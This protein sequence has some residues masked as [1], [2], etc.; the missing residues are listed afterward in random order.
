[1]SQSWEDSVNVRSAFGLD[2]AGYSSG[3]SPLA[4]GWLRSDHIDVRIA[5][6][7]VFSVQRSGSFQFADPDEELDLFRKMVGEAPV[8]VDVPID[9]QGLPSVQGAHRVWQLTKRAV[10]VALGALPPLAD[11]IGAPVARLRRIL[12]LTQ[13][14]SLLGERIFESY[15]AGSL[16]QMN[17]GCRYKASTADV[18]ESGAWASENA[19]FVGL[20][21][22]LHVHA[23]VGTVLTDDHLDAVL[24]ALC[25]VLPPE[26]LLADDAL[27]EEI[28]R[29]L[30][31]AHNLPHEDAII[32][33]AGYVLARACSFELRVAI[34]HDVADLF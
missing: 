3:R 25:R 15:P 22:A 20:L 27:R 14:G 4:R 21:G 24:C 32:P 10:D 34:Q 29:V 31:A 17:Q 28:T 9:L 19:E 33:P 2:L 11:R 16:R 1:M 13:T 7:G 12:E 8:V 30:A 18:D 23:A 26:D 6:R 5:N